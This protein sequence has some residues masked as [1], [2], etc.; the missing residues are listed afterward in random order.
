MNKF[1]SVLTHKNAR[2]GKTPT[3]VTRTHTAVVYKV[4]VYVCVCQQQVVLLLPLVV[5][6]GSLYSSHTPVCSLFSFTLPLF[7]QFH[8]WLDIVVFV[9]LA[10]SINEQCCF[11]LF[12][13]VRFPVDKLLS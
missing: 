9:E 12:L 4:A 7:L 5:V 1:I 10:A 13:V 6:I 8:P 2:G 3:K 11:S